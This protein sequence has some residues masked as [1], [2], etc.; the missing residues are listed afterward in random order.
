M[1]RRAHKAERSPSYLENDSSDHFGDD[2]TLMRRAHKAEWS[3]SN[4]E[5]ESMQMY[6]IEI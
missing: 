3:P 5:N 1:V 2:S 4:W 6:I